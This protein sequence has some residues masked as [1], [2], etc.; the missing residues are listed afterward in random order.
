M[1]EQSKKRSVLKKIAA[2]ALPL[3]LSGIL[4]GNYI[5]KQIIQKPQTEYTQ[6]VSPARENNTQQ[7]K[8]ETLE[9]ICK[10]HQIDQ[11]IKNRI[12]ELTETQKYKTT[13]EA[14][15]I[16]ATK[17]E[18]YFQKA[19]EKTGLE[20][21]L[22][23]AYITV[24]S[25][26]TGFSHNAESHRGA[27]GPA[28]MLEQAAREVDLKIIK[29]EDGEILY[30]ERRDPKK[31]I[32]ASAEYLKKYADYAGDTILGLA[33]Y[34]AGPGALER[35]IKI[36]KTDTFAELFKKRPET[37]R[38]VI[39]VISRT[40]ILKNIQKYGLN[41]VKKPLYSKMMDYTQEHTLKEGETINSLANKYNTAPKWIKK[42]NP[43]IINIDKVPA[44]IKIHVPK[45]YKTNTRK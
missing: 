39:E 21:E 12:K 31:V 18:D 16:E 45:I 36:K 3:F 42:A 29:S 9:N 38:Y 35:L 14:M 24:E 37:M 28:Q 2:A 23:K 6:Q 19:A 4:L 44:G 5:S 25:G 30:D 34:N 41:L 40:C 27:I 33:S 13:L 26:H 10:Y 15:F 32:I 8:T 11:K 22:I 43:A 17:Y 1:E 7:E 20:K